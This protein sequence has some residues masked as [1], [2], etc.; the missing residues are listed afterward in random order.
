MTLQQ[1]TNWSRAIRNVRNDFYQLRRDAEDQGLTFCRAFCDS[2]LEQVRN[3]EV[4][5]DRE[6]VSDVTPEL[7]FSISSGSRLSPGDC[8]NQ[9]S[10]KNEK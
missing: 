1:R 10:T 6:R 4:R 2:V 5:L 3:W 9:A 8:V 7:P